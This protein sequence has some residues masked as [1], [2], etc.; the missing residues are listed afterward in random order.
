MTTVAQIGPCVGCG[1]C[2]RIENDLCKECK[3]KFPKP[4][5]ADIMRRIRVD[6]AFAAMCYERCIPSRRPDFVRRFGLPPGC[7]EA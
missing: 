6:P 1:R 2:S 5:V 3:S 4:V 7:Q